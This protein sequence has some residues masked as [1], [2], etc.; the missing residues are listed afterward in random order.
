MYVCMYMYV[1]KPH[2]VQHLLADL[3]SYN[4]D[5][6]VITET[7]FKN[8]HNDSAISV[9]GYTVLRRDRE[10]RRG[11]GVALYVRSSLPLSACNFSGDDLTYELLWGALVTLLWAPCI[12]RRV[13][14]VQ[15][16]PSWITSKHAW[17]NWLGLSFS[18][19]NTSW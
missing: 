11:G 15:W 3:H 4:T 6:A 17:K 2:A 13:L 18:S 9:P 7:H 12:T 10:R 8:K 19:Y 16:S 1:C 14:V 5:V